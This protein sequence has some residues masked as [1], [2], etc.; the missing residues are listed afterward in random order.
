MSQAR[1]AASTINYLEA[2]EKSEKSRRPLIA[3]PNNRRENKLRQLL[4]NES[5]SVR[6]RYRIHRETSFAGD[7][8]MGQ[9]SLRRL[10][11]TAVEQGGRGQSIDADAIVVMQ[12][13]CKTYMTELMA[14][15][16]AIQESWGD[17]G[18]LCPVHIEEAHRRLKRD[19]LAAN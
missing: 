14:E 1:Q 11:A 12:S 5:E 4:M 8:M 6:L 9:G 3:D 16:M 7:A 10:M 18:Q 17:S 13:F 15:A 19:G 2:Q